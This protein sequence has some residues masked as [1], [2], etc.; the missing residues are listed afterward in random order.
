[1]LEY[2]PILDS[3]HYLLKFSYS[4]QLSPKTHLNPQENFFPLKSSPRPLLFLFL[5]F[6]SSLP[7]SRSFSSWFSQFS[8]PGTQILQTQSQ[9]W[10]SLWMF[11]GVKKAKSQRQKWKYYIIY[12]PLFSMFDTVMRDEFSR[13]CS[14][15]ICGSVHWLHFLYRQASF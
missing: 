15:L 13:N 4:F 9:E 8:L 3:L 11:F 2:V 5:L 12:F 6:K 7:T 14:L 10:N 1:M